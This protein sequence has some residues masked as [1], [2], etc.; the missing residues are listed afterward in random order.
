V[1]WMQLLSL[2]F[3]VVTLG[4]LALGTRRIWSYRGLPGWIWS[5]IAWLVFVVVMLW[6]M[7]S[8]V[9]L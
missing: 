1:A 4:A 3:A 9:G 7:G 8:D 2:F 5:A 6:W